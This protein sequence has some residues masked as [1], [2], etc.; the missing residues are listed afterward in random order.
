[1]HNEQNYVRIIEE[2]AGVPVKW[3]GVGPEREATIRR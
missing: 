3:I 2:A 1:M